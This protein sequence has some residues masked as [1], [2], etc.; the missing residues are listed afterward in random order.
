[1]GDLLVSVGERVTGFGVGAEVL[2]DA[3]DPLLFDEASA[4]HVT[5]PSVDE[6]NTY[7]AVG[8][9]VCGLDP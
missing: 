3:T 8:A 1:M 5:P 2:G 6:R 4:P 9:T 7:G